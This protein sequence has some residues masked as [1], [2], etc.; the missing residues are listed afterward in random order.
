MRSSGFRYVGN[1]VT[2]VG[3]AECGL[4]QVVL[5]KIMLRRTKT[6]V[7]N[8]KPIL[9]LP[10]RL[11]NVVNCEFDADERAFYHSVE[12]KVNTSLEQLQQ[13]DINKAYTSVLVLLLRLRQGKFLCLDYDNRLG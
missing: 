5:Q 3:R 13:G 1:S 4:F 12:E 9:E 2:R 7:I 8:G 6:T 10:D 11:V